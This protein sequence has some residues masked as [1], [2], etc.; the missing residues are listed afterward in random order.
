VIGVL[1]AVVALALSVVFLLAAQGEDTEE[2]ELKLSG[3]AGS[4]RQ[5]QARQLAA[6]TVDGSPTG[7]GTIL[8]DISLGGPTDRI[9][10][11]PTPI[12][13][14]FAGRFTNGSIIGVLQGTVTPAPNGPPSTEGTIE[15]TGGTGDFEDA[16]G[17]AEY[18]D[19]GTNPLETK[20]TITITGRIEY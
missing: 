6:G 17:S 11:G 18:A 14:R 13:A 15:I 8:M 16:E 7:S 4:V 10:R 9:L 20:D 19:A 2:H 5:V 1:I 3:R 12:S